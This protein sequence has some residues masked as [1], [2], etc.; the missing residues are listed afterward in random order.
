MTCFKYMKAEVYLGILRFQLTG[1]RK[2]YI[3][4]RFC[5]E[6]APNCETTYD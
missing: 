5:N 3:S 1:T 6:K 2:V 4:K